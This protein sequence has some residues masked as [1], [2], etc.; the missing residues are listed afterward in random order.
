M[1]YL[2]FPNATDEV[3]PARLQTKINSWGMGYKVVAAEETVKPQGGRGG[4]LKKQKQALEEAQ[5][6]HPRLIDVAGLKLGLRL[7]GTLSPNTAASRTCEEA[8]KI[9]NPALPN[10]PHLCHDTAPGPS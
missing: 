3:P 7:S 5:E 2:V 8:Q 9:R 6:N 10:S 1:I 4:S